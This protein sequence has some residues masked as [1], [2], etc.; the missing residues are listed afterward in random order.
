MSTNIMNDGIR[1]GV[2]ESETG[3]FQSMP[4]EGAPDFSSRVSPRITV[5]MIEQSVK[6]ENL[7]SRVS[8]WNGDHID[9]FGQL[10]LDDVFI[11]TKSEVDRVYHVFLFEEAILFFK[12]GG[13]RTNLIGTF[14]KKLAAPSLRT[15]PEIQ[16]T[17]PLVVKGRVFFSNVIQAV[18]FPKKSMASE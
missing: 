12:E 15:V 11:V 5:N 6:V 8:N 18:P 7:R 4:T 13:K 9:N 17:T 2:K 3:P 14:L 16:E 10:L 1:E